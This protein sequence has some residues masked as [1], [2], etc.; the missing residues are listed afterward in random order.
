MNDALC[1]LPKLK[2]LFCQRLFSKGNIYIGKSCLV[3]RVISSFFFF[4]EFVEAMIEAYPIVENLR[5]R[6]PTYH[7]I[8]FQPDQT[9]IFS[10]FRFPHLTSLS[11]CGFHLLDG[12]VLLPV[13]VHFQFVIQVHLND[14]IFGIFRSSKGAQSWRSSTW[15]LTHWIQHLFHQTWN[16]LSVL[17]PSYVISDNFRTQFIVICIYY[18]NYYLY[19][20][21][22]DWF[23]NT[24]ITP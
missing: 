5:L 7:H 24:V 10:C 22:S 15:I 17:L 20:C 12:A 4:V 1:K 18:D 19:L 14:Y 9:P 8:P 2:T 16:S 21:H 6:R 23:S 13:R 11:L 3:G